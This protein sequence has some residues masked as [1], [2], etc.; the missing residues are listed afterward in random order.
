MNFPTQ[1]EIKPI[2]IETTHKGSSLRENKCLRAIW[3][4]KILKKLIKLKKFFRSLT[5]L[6]F[7]INGFCLG[8][9]IW[10][11]IQCM[12]KY[13]EKPKGTEISMKQSASVPFP[14]ITVCG[15]YGKDED[16]LGMGFNKT[17]LENVCGIR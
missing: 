7:W 1:N 15:S 8:F 13:I 11:T 2:E 6:S 14:V 3:S 5:S 9:V 16:G 4:F 12:T 10:Q 17:Y